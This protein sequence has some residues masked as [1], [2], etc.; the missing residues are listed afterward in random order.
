MK[1]LSKKEFTMKRYGFLSLGFF[2]KNFS[3]YYFF[4]DFYDFLV[5][6]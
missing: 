1:I 4:P 6:I 3:F 2:L 5:L